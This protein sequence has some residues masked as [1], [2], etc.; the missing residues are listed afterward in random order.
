MSSSIA[1]AR[2]RDELQALMLDPAERPFVCD[3][4]AAASYADHDFRLL[5][6]AGPLWR[7]S[8][9]AAQVI[10]RLVRCDRERAAGA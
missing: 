1:L 3:Q 4:L 2:F 9:A 10:G 5:A 7:R 6:L 8:I